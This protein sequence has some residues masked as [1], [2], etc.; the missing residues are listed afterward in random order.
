M[1]TAYTNNGRCFKRHSTHRK[2]FPVTIPAVRFI[3]ILPIT[4][5]LARV[6]MVPEPQIRI[7]SHRV[8]HQTHH[9]VAFQ[10]ILNAISRAYMQPQFPGVALAFRRYT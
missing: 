8:L 10:L 7:R 2:E 5:F 6:V 1:T 4:Q 3:T 9:V